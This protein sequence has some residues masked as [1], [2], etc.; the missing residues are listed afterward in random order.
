MTVAKSRGSGPSHPVRTAARGAAY[1]HLGQQ[2]IYGD[3]KIEGFRCFWWIISDVSEEVAF[4][5]NFC[6]TFNDCYVTYIRHR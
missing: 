5:V 3:C 1:L 4:C 2:V 6:T